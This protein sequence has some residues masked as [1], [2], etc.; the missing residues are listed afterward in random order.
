MPHAGLFVFRGLYM[1]MA[2]GTAVEAEGT[3]AAPPETPPE[4]I[5]PETDSDA[6]PETESAPAPETVEPSSAPPASVVVPPGLDS[7]TDEQIAAH[8]RVASLVARQQESAR[9]R[10][11]AEELARLVEGDF[12]LDRM[13]RLTQAA[14]E[15]GAD[16]TTLRQALAVQLRAYGNGRDKRA[17]DIM[18]RILEAAAPK[19]VTASRETEDAYTKALTSWQAG[20]TDLDQVIL[21]RYR[22][23]IE[24]A[25]NAERQKHEGRWRK[26]Y[27]ARRTTEA[28]VERDRSNGE[29]RK[30]S[31]RPTDVKGLVTGGTSLTEAAIKAMSDEE[32][33]RRRPEILAWQ[34]GGITRS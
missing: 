23:D 32:Y 10:G 3:A 17:S 15:Q 8:P 14:I 25:V 4:L 24:A 27:D 16:A 5:Q 2:E 26:E 33:T 12:H 30:G 20:D 28:E 6:A 29:G 7:L 34:S 21:T 9:R 13:A 18:L 11:E 19:D 22:R 31:P 1:V